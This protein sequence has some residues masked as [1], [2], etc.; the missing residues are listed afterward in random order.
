MPANNETRTLKSNTLEQF[1]QKSNEVSL[2]LGDNALI[3]SRIL[4]KTVSYTAVAS[5]TLFTGSGLR[6]ELKPEETLDD[7]VAG[8][9]F[10]VAGLVPECAEV[11]DGVSAAA[12]L[13][14]KS[15]SA[16][17]N[18]ASVPPCVE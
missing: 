17:S 6:F 2:H 9:S 18:N 12:S 8:E 10:S 7:V 1:R 3:D 13:A 16:S 11:P 14:E 4:D 5:Q 15:E